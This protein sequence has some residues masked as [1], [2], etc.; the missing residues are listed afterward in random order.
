MAFLGFDGLAKYEQGWS[1]LDVIGKEEPRGTKSL[2]LI[3]VRTS[4]LP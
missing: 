2:I 3:T 4:Y 1:L